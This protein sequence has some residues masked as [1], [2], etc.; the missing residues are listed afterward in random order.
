MFKHERYHMHIKMYFQF[1]KNKNKKDLSSRLY[2]VQS[3]IIQI[4][5]K[6]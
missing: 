2:I 1:L 4:A 5:F 3:L 6:D